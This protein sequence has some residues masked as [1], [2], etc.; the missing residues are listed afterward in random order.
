MYK[1]DFPSVDKKDVFLLLSFYRKPHPNLT[2]HRWEWI[3][4]LLNRP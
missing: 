1:S 4:N 3:L 2:N